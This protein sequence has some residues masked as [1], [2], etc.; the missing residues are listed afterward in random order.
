MLKFMKNKILIPL[1]V[2]GALAAFF[3]FRYGGGDGQSAEER[4][5]LILESVMRA[6][7]QVH[8]SPREINDSFSDRVYHKVLDEVDYEKKFFTQKD[9]NILKKYEFKIDDEIKNGNVDFYDKLDAIFLKRIDDADTFY[10]E[11]LKTPYTFNGNDKEELDGAKLGYAADDKEL[12]DRWRVYLKYKVLAKYVELKDDRAR[13]DTAKDEVVKKE[14]R[15]TDAELEADA[16]ESVRKNQQNYFKRLRKWKEDERYALY[17]NAIVTN[18]DPHTDYLPP[19]DKQ[20]FDEEMSGTFFGIGAQLKDDNGKIKTASVITGSPCWKEGELKAGDEIMKVAQGD[21]EPVD[22][23]GYEIEDAVTLIRGPKGTIVKLTVKSVDGSSKVIPITR[24]EVLVEDKFAKSAIIKSNDGPVGY[25]YL[26]E[27]YADFQGINGRRCADD[28]AIEVTKLKNAGVKGIILD[29]RYNGGGSLNDVVDMAGLFVGR[30]PVVQVKGTNEAPKTDVSGKDAIYNGPM[31]IMVNQGSASASEIMAAAMQDYKR[32]VIVGS[33][34]YG[35]GTVQKIVPLDELID[36]MTR[37]KMQADALAANK[38]ASGSSIGS[39]KITIQKFYRINGGS[40]QLKGVTP[41]IEL[42]DPYSLLESG[43]RND[44]A[45]LQWDEIAPAAYKQVQNAPNISELAAMSK[46][47]I[48][49]NPTF[50][51]IEESAVRIKK[52]KDDNLVSLNETEYRKEMEETNAASKKLEEVQK[53]I[54]PYNITNPKEDSAKINEDSTSI[55]KNNDWIK[56]LKKDIYISETVNIINDMAKA[57][58]NV[59]A[60][61]K[62]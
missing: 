14:L 52:Q 38:S 21:K 25:I 20:R 31:A 42:P 17:V 35:K 51:L 10:K 19:V 33:P 30:G 50:S 59:E 41:D 12:K 28:I 11:V 32:A 47:R 43:E 6:V 45:A 37:M 3:S 7:N 46:S 9:I 13:K 39:L 62:Q 27:F 53:K 16:R 24:G 61:V 8:Y 56:N 34:T 26:P 40:T 5:A 22:I 60:A 54:T 29:L 55:A 57:G 18:E 49:A 2:I 1:V 23:Q 44:K 36:P 15:K 58:M 48:A 4:K